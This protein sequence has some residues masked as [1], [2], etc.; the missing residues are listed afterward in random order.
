MDLLEVTN[1]EDL[2]E[3]LDTIDFFLEMVAAVRAT[4]PRDPLRALEDKLLDLRVRV[5]TS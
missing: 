3:T 1:D 5:T 4:K 2:A